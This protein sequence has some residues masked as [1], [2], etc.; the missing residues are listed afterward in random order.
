MLSRTTSKTLG[1]LLAGILIVGIGGWVG[2]RLWGAFELQFCLH[3]I[4]ERHPNRPD[5]SSSVS[6]MAVQNGYRPISRWSPGERRVVL[7]AAGLR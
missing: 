2:D 3:L 4:E 7:E 1:C 6:Y 5:L